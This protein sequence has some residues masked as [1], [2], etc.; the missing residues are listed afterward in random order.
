M[1][2]KLDTY[3]RHE[4]LLKLA[5]SQ[6][7]DTKTRRLNVRARK[8]SV[9]CLRRLPKK[10]AAVHVW[11]VPKGTDAAL[12][13]PHVPGAG[14]RALSDLRVV[15][16]KFWVLNYSALRLKWHSQSQ[17]YWCDAFAR[18]QGLECEDPSA[19]FDRMERV[20]DGTPMRPPAVSPEAKPCAGR[21][22]C[23]AGVTRRHP[24]GGRCKPTLLWAMMSWGLG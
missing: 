15:A 5:L 19:D 2:K 8:S 7:P 23:N 18:R 21:L 16:L 20:G 10:A 12:L 4:P 13:S 24:R 22:A 1:Y 14:L 6:R 11:E 9:A 17:S 3:K